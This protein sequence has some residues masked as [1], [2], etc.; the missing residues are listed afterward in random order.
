[1]RARNREP[2]R[3]L[4]GFRRGDRGRVLFGQ[5]LIPDGTGRLTV[6]DKVEVIEALAEPSRS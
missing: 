1:M 4:A 2:L 5:N 6:G 3:T